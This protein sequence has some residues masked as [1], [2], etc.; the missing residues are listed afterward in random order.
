M[1]IWNS[2]SGSKVIVMCHVMLCWV[3]FGSLVVFG[4]FFYEVV[5]YLFHHS[6]CSL[7]LVT[8]R[9]DDRSIGWLFG[10]LV[11]TRDTNGLRITMMSF[12][13]RVLF[14]VII[15][16]FFSSSH[17]FAGVICRF[18][19]VAICMWSYCLPPRKRLYIRCPLSCSSGNNLIGVW[20]CV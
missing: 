15:F 9:P 10:C 13:G 18:F 14:P 3:W 17:G 19:L 8:S 2:A 12:F 1:H 4:V 5:F 6:R 16:L 20:S 11:R 7:F